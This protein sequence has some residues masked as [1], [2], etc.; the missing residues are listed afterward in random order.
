METF[1]T[2]APPDGLKLTPLFSVPLSDDGARIKRLETAVQSLH[3]DFDTIMPTMVRMAVMEK[4]MKELIDQM[5]RLQGNAGSEGRNESGTPDPGFM[6]PVRPDSAQQDAVDVSS[7][8]AATGQQTSL[9]TKNEVFGPFQPAAAAPSTA[10][11]QQAPAD[12]E[13]ITAGDVNGIR[14]GDHD[15]MTRIV[16]DTSAQGSFTASLD[17]EGKHLIVDLARFDRADLAPSAPVK[18]RLVASYSYEGG[19]LSLELLRPAKIVQQQ[20]LP[21]E[22]KSGFRIVVDISG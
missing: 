13:K 3:D 15:D 12:P 18:S 7:L 21:P 17:K 11:P 16:L 1:R 20:T 5:E 6:G 8:P 10:L 4:S 2:L 14:I 9:S 19:I 22:G